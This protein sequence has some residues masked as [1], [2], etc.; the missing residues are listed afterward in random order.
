MGQ[1]ESKVMELV[2]KMLAGNQQSLSRLITSVERD[3]DEVPLIMKGIHSRIG[4]AY[5]IGFTGPPGA[6]K[7]TL[8]DK[9][10]AMSR[11]KGLSVGIIAVDPTSPFSGGH[12]LAIGYGCSS[13]I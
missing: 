6:G 1:K 11:A 3:T 7:S 4:N 2:E 13:T 10:T 12:C 9:F 5:C 8:V